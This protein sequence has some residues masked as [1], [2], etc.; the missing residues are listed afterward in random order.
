MPTLTAEEL[1]TLTADTVEKALG[2]EVASLGKRGEYIVYGGSRPHYLHLDDPETPMC[3]CS[4]H[5]WR[6]RLCK[7]ITAALI[8]RGDFQMYCRLREL[9]E[10]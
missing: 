3:D 2:L 7:H 10:E 5:L 1:R 4:D 6:S 8:A 9:L